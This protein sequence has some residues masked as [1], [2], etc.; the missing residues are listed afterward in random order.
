MARRFLDLEDLV[1]PNAQTGSNEVVFNK[2]QVLC[3]LAVQAPA[4]LDGTCTFHVSLD[5]GATFVPL[6]SGAANI[7]IPSSTCVVID[8]WAWDAIKIVSDAGGGEIP[9]KT[10]KCKGIRDY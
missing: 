1:I 4:A 2:D 5:G 6:R 7:T 3:G 10:F 9:A 8:M